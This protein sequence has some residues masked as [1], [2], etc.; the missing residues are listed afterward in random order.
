M[1][2]FRPD[3]MPLGVSVIGHAFSEAAVAALADALHRG[4]D[5]ETKAFMQYLK[6]AQAFHD[7]A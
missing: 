4:P 5:R 7:C 1:A 3:G 6:M 2:G